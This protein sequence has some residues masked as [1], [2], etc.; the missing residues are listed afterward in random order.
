LQAKEQIQYISCGSVPSDSTEVVDDQLVLHLNRTSSGEWKGSEIVSHDW[1]PQLPLTGENGIEKFEVQLG[2]AMESDLLQLPSG[3][4]FGFELYS[5]V[6][7][8]EFS[9]VRPN[10]TSS[11]PNSAFQIKKK[12]KDASSFNLVQKYQFD[13]TK[14]TCDYFNIVMTHEKVSFSSTNEEGESDLS[15]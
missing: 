13:V 14:K 10:L 5:N 3:S 1:D 8:F 7:S 15:M 9:F 6:W 4:N 11:V 12:E 2:I